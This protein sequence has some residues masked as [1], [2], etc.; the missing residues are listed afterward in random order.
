MTLINSTISFAPHI[1]N[2]AIEWFKNTFISL[3]TECSL[4]ERVQLLQI[5]QQGDADD[6]FA[7]QIHFANKQNYTLYKEKYADDFDQMLVL[8]FQNMMGIFTT[9]L[10]EI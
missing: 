5:E 9:I 6:C 7:L 10:H 4:V 2:E 1:Q 3:L 8:K